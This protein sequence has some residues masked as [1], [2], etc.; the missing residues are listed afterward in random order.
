MKAKDLHLDPGYYY[1]DNLLT[2]TN[3]VLKK[4]DFHSKFSTLEFHVK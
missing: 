3:M 4:R 2:Q 1:Y